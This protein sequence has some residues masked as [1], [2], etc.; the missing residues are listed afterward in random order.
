[1]QNVSMLVCQTIVTVSVKERSDIGL[2]E[3]LTF[4]FT[5]RARG[6]SVFTVIR[7]TLNS[8]AY[9]LTR[10]DQPTSVNA[11]T[12][13]VQ[14]TLTCIVTSTTGNARLTRE[15][16]KKY[17]KFVFKGFYFKRQENLAI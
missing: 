12:L 16:F 5:F 7:M 15:H 9:L 4:V 13:R 8:V 17:F 14:G 10:K 2:S 11:R 1:M 6:L 3:K